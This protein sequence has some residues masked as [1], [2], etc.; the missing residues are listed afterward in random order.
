MS[1]RPACPGSMM[2]APGNNVVL[3]PGELAEA[4]LT[5][6]RWGARQL[7]GTA[8]RPRSQTG[9]DLPVTNYGKPLPIQLCSTGGVEGWV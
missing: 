3:D 9:H 1:A 5:R 6:Q 4:L 7:N 8:G 2:I